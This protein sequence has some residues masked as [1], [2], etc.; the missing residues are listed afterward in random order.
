M[1]DYARL[2]II[3][4]V[5]LFLLISSQ[6]EISIISSD[7]L[8]KYRK[9]YIGNHLQNVS[10]HIIFEFISSKLAHAIN[11]RKNLSIMKMYSNFGNI[12]CF[13]L[14]SFFC[15]YLYRT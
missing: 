6:I 14:Q 12:P 1:L 3:Q 5:N 9:M 8:V 13:F 7:I 11:H 15:G 2:L 4:F 10:F